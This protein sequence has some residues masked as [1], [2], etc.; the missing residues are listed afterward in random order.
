MKAILINDDQSLTWGETASLTPGPREVLVKTKATALNRADLLQRKGL[1]P[2]PPG[3]SEIMGLEAAGEVVAC[4][5][6]VQHLRV[7]DAVCALLEGGGYAE[8]FVRDERLV[9]PKPE[10]LT[11]EETAAIPEVF[12]TAYLNLKIEGKLSPNERVLV[13][14]GASGVGT[15]AIQL[16]KA[17]GNPVL[18]TASQHKLEHLTPLGATQTFD[19]RQEGLF[20]AI[21]QYTTQLPLQDDEEAKGVDVILDPVGAKYLDNNLRLLRKRGRLVLI[22]LLGGAKAELNLGLCLRKRLRVVGSVLRAR[23][24]EEKYVITE[25]LKRDIWHLFSDK[26]L[27]PI[28]YKTFPIEEAE[29]A[30]TLMASNENIGKIVLSFP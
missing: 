28:V 11:W 29:A 9:L 27:K 18:T 5:E 25:S 13:H 8:Y 3:A 23:S 17:W 15:A 19:R 10:G 6:D 20:D 16:C 7:G 2:P 24:F 30:H 4:G 26:T 12:Y 14:A 1:Y 21:K 22:G